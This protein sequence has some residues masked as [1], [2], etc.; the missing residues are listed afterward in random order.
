VAGI[1]DGGPPVA[2]TT[3]DGHA[4]TDTSRKVGGEVKAGTHEAKAAVTG[5]GSKP[6]D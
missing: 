6:K 4:I 1:Q 2:Q 3:T 5:D